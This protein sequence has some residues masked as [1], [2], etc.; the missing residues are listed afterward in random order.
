MNSVSKGSVRTAAFALGAICLLGLFLGVRG[1]IDRP[2]GGE[3]TATSTTS[4]QTAVR[5]SMASA[6]EARPY[7]GEIAASSAPAAQLAQVK[8]AAPKPKPPPVD[9]DDNAD[10]DE[11]PA[12][13][14]VGPPGPPPPA[15]KPAATQDDNAPPY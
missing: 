11:P 14:L 10:S 1:G 7:Q 5:A 12:P 3:D 15:A 6:V 13:Q 9:T 2:Y 4:A 8:P